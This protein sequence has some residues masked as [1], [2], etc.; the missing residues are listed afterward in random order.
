M[1]IFPAIDL[2]SGQCVRLFKG[3]LNQATIFN[4]SPAAQAREFENLGF[5]FLHLV[6][7]D[8]AVAGSVAN[9][10]SVKEILQSIKIPVQLGGGIRSLAAIERWL[11]LGVNRVILGT[12]AAKNPELVREACKKFPEKILVGI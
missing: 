11:E 2:K 3:N 10:E 12:V 5:K 7:L 9:T 6:D 8:G 1:I 4:H